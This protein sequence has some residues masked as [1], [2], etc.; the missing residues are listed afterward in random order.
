[1]KKIL[2]STICLI[3]FGSLMA[4]RKDKKP[5]DRFD[6]LD[7]ELQTVLDTWKAAGFAVAVVEKDKIVYAK[8]FGYRDYETQQPVTPNT[9]FAIGSV[10]KSFTASILGKLREE[11]KVDFAMPPSTYIPRFR[12]Y[13]DELNTQVTVRDLMCHRTGLPRHD[14]AWYLFPTE[15]RDALMSRIEHQEPFTGVREQWYYNNFMYLTQGVIAEKITGKTWEDNIRESFLGPLGMQ[16]S[17]VSIKELE[18]AADASYGYSLD[19]D[20]KIQKEDYYRIR[21][22]APAGSIN[23]SVN[24]M[25]NWLITWIYGGKFKDEQVIPTDYVREAMSSQMIVNAALPGSEHPDLHMAAY[26]YGWFLSSY[27]GHYRVEH[28]GNING[29]SASACFFPSDSIGIVVLV[30]QDG[31]SVPSVVRNIIADRMLGIGY[32]DWNAEL[33]D[34]YAKAREGQKEARKGGGSSQVK[35]TRPSHI[36]QE[37]TGEYN[38]PGYGTFEMTTSGDSLFARFPEETIWLRHYHYDVFEPFFVKDGKPDTTGFPMPIKFSF[39]SNVMGD[40]SGLSVPLE[41]TLDP[42][43]FKRNPAE[44]AVEASTLEQYVGE[45]QLGP[46]TMKVYT[47][48]ETLYVL[49]P[50]QPDYV[51]VPLGEHKF[52]IKVL[53]GFKVEFLEGK[54]GFGSMKFIQPN[55]TFEAKRKE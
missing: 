20:E 53:D 9:L 6:G 55:G 16:R 15:D 5:V 32:R 29:F 52:A 3:L 25:S 12:F 44:V 50:G 40:V 26:G 11:E 7:T 38:H 34:N 1:M 2:L 47:Q 21:G 54:E 17:N 13:N 31:S 30:N 8:G 14:L 28:G 23:S 51:L 4:Q 49:V 36:L 19:Q 27:S 42:I 10:T 24:E 37:Y 48:D 41:P 35:G 18:A 45:Y 33:H 22:M 39:S 46:Q 43:E